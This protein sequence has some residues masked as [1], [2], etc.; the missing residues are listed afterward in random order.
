MPQFDFTTLFIVLLSSLISIFSY[1]RFFA[2]KL[3]PQIITL[4][5]FRTKKL[6]KEN[7]LNQIFLPNL[8]CY[9]IMIQKK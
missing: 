8:F 6:F 5:K 7:L 4:F 2:L 1:Y 3:L 9:S